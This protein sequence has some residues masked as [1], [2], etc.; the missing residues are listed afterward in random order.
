MIIIFD[1]FGNFQILVSLG[2]EISGYELGIGCIKPIFTW[3]KKLD[4]SSLYGWILLYMILNDVLQN[5]TAI[6]RV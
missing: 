2:V 6:G 1:K 5:F 4:F 3:Y